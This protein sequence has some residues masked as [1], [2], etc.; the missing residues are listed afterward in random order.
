MDLHINAR[1]LSKP[2]AIFAVL[3]FC[4]SVASAKTNDTIAIKHALSDYNAALN[5]GN[6]GAV[7]PLYTVDGVFMPPFSPSAIGKMEL[8]HAYDVVFKELT[9]DVKFK[10]AELVVLAPNWAYMRTNSAGTTG[11]RSTSQVS[12]DATAIQLE[13]R[14]TCPG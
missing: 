1:S 3:A 8:E 5:A 6:T 2:L 14:A 7:L 10:I 12:R 4:A 11:H 9:F 13:V